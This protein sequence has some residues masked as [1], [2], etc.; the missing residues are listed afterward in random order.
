VTQRDLLVC[1]TEREGRSVDNGEGVVIDRQGETFVMG[2]VKGRKG[3]R[4]ARRTQSRAL[5]TVA[6]SGKTTSCGDK[7]AF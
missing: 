1:T 6:R 5:D 2:D 3:M 7:Y 4:G